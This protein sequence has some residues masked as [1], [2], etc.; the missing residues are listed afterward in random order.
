MFKLSLRSLSYLGAPVVLLSCLLPACSDGEPEVSGDSGGTTAGELG[1]GGSASG[2]A[3]GVA[4]GGASGHEA[5]TGG[6]ESVSSGGMGSGGRA[7]G[8]GSGAGGSDMEG[9]GSG[10][11]GIDGSGGSLA[12]MVD[13]SPGCSK[14]SAM[15]T[16]PNGQVGYPDGYDGSTP[17][18]VMFAF[19]GAGGDESS[20]RNQWGNTPIGDKYLMIYLKSSGSQWGLQADKGRVNDAMDAVL[21]EGCVDQNRVFAVGHSSGAQMIVQLL[22]D[23]FSDFD[24]VIPVASSVYC[25]K[26]DPVPVLNFHGLDDQERCKYGLDDCDGRKDI[27]PYRTSNG[28][29]ESKQ[30]ADLDV[31]NSCS[32]DI[33]PGC[34]EFEGCSEPTFFCN[35]NDPQ[36]GTSNHGVPCFATPAMMDFL[37]RFDPQ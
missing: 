24:A 11:M 22:C 1:S 10:G 32:G 29:M 2:G 33:D 15:F 13:P 7:T 27:V 21:T 23:G 14:G 37:G 35:H 20:L 28:C 25:Q 30:P 31:G 19:H 12:T 17:V 4:S 18:P 5:A 6:M 26:W 16:V 34:V 3:Q 36:Y 9:G 8:N